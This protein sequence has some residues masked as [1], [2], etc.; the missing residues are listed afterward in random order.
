MLTKNFVVIG[1]DLRQV[2]L[3]NTFAKK[4]QEYNVYGMFLDEKADLSPHVRYS[5]DIRLVFPQSDIIVFPLPMLDVNDN[6][7]T[8]FSKSTRSFEE[9]LD[10]ISP[11][12]LVFGGMIPERIHTAAKKKGITLIDYYKREE[13]VVLNS[14]PTAEGAVE[15]AL[16]E[17]P[18]T[19]FGSRCL[20]LGFGRCAKTLAKLL[21]AF[22]AKV[23]VAARSFS[24]LAWA[25]V[26]GC[27][28]I[29]LS[30]LTEHLD[31]ADIVFNTIPSIVL[32]RGTL[33]KL[34]HDCLVIDLASKPGGVDFEA[35]SELGIKT[36]W[37]LS[38]PG[39]VAPLSASEII[40]NTITN[41]L[42]ERR[43]L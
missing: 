4:T 6:I 41:I 42:G 37:A 14:I 19:L 31:H 18:S 13:F 38:L 8:P 28:S 36:I 3:A 23:T 40:L 16:T 24:D 17:T 21:V 33:T 20:I 2:H 1:G 35:A 9:C 34:N 15:I 30:D 26:Y 12:S 10:Y 22:G 11:E 29:H 43:V 32:D 7:N 39:K 5:S 27:Q 25:E